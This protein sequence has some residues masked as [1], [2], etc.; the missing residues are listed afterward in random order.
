[1]TET[2]LRRAWALQGD[3][4]GKPGRVELEVK[5]RHGALERARIGGA[6]VTVIEGELRG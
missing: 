4:I 6:A 1:V 3:A 2:P 5:G